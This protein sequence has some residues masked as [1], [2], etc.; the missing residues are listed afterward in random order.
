[1][2]GYGMGLKAYRP[3]LEDWGTLRRL[4]QAVRE[5]REAGDLG[6]NFEGFTELVSIVNGK[7][8]AFRQANCRQAWRRA[9]WSSGWNLCSSRWLH[10]LSSFA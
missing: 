9:I 5:F 6:G 10:P 8:M 1:M 2:K 7:C 3:L 4:L